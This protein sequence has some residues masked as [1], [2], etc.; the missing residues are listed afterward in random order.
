MIPE[1]VE[2]RIAN[3]FFHNYLPNEVMM[4]VVDKL[5][6]PCIYTQE[7]DLDFD[8]LVRGAIEIIKEQLEDKS[9]K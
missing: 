6:P 1:E 3:Y 5:L 9:F 4:E 7:E 8:E 2:N